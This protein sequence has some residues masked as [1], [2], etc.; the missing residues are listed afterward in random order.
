MTLS[1]EQTRWLLTARPD[2]WQLDDGAS[3]DLI[4]EC[5]AIG[6]VEVGHRRGQWKLTAAG[7][8]VWCMLRGR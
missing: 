7:H 8:H 2:T 6:L 5:I 4:Y 3:D 1:D